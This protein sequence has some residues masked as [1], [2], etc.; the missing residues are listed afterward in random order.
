MSLGSLNLCQSSAFAVFFFTLTAVYPLSAEAQETPSAP[1]SAETPAP[2]A[3]TPPAAQEAAAVPAAPA[4]PCDEIQKKLDSSLAD[5]NNILAQL[6]HAYDQKNKALEEQEKTALALEAALA[7]KEDLT[8]RLKV[9]EEAKPQAE[10]K[11]EAVSDIARPAVEV[12]PAPSGPSQTEIQLRRDLEIAERVAQDL[13]QE[14]KALKNGQS[15]E[16]MA[17]EDR[18]RTF[19]AEKMRL[20]TEK[21]ELEK[22]L[23]DWQLKTEEAL[24]ENAELKAKKTKTPP[25]PAQPAPGAVL[26]ITQERDRLFKENAD[27]HYNLGVFFAQ[28]RDFTRA[29][30]EFQRAVEMRPNDS[31]A[32]YN[33]AKIYADQLGEKEK[34]VVHFEQY[35]QLNPNAPDKNWVEGYVA[36]S[37]AWEGEEKLS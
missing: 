37:R 15:A 34:A 27:M 7:E 29:A 22:Q 19:E 30:K 25:P 1:V 2:A 17:A 26:E 13:I 36:S 18:V 21:Q 10:A 12:K 35:L 4:S 14:L 33:L 20:E 11:P 28:S 23:K 3:E 6:K 24:K 16:I 31:A 9:F 8:K 5:R 32:H